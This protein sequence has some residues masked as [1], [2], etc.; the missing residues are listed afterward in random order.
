MEE[1]EAQ[2]AGKPLEA[3]SSHG[4][5]TTKQSKRKTKWT[6]KPKNNNIDIH[7]NILC[8]STKEGGL[9]SNIWNSWGTGLLWYY[10]KFYYSCQ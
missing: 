2:T 5:A 9:G 3:L 1:D 10:F 4:A 7:Y 8:I 6:R